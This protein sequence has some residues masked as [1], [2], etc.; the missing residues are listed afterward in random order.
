MHNWLDKFN[1]LRV[2]RTGPTAD[3]KINAYGTQLRQRRCRLRVGPCSLASSREWWSKRHYSCLLLETLKFACSLSLENIGR[4]HQTTSN[5]N[6]GWMGR[7][8]GID[9]GA[10]FGLTQRAI[11]A[12]AASASAPTT[13][14]TRAETASVLRQRISH[15]T[16]GRAREG[17]SS[18]GFESQE[19][20]RARPLP[21]APPRPAGLPGRRWRTLAGQG[22]N[23]CGGGVGPGK[24]TAGAKRHHRTCLL[25]RGRRRST[26]VAAVLQDRASCEDR[27]W[28]V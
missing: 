1:E 21:V 26:S 15:R 24:G 25:R 20:R 3:A 4:L 6:G 5:C 16:W 8:G 27:G 13:R 22:K 10:I 18:F 2:V 12:E 14:H 7:G 17:H 23:G 9:G 19:K 28:G 11:L